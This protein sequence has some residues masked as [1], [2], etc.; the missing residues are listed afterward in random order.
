MLVAS[1]V[2]K[3]RRSRRI[4]R[5]NLPTLGSDDPLLLEP[6]QSTGV[7]P[8]ALRNTHCGFARRLDT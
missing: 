8:T 4:G 1:C 2:L 6:S 5:K 7:L 3:N